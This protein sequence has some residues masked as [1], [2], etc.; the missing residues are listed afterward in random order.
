VNLLVKEL[1]SL[2]PL[3]ILVVLLQASD[4]IYDPFV[5]C[6]DM[7]AWTQET[8]YLPGEGTPTAIAFMI[9]ALLA[10][11][12]LFPR[13]HDDGT[14]HFLHSL[15]VSRTRIFLAKLAAAFLV[16]TLGV[17]WG[18]FTSFLVQLPNDETFT[19]HQFR[20][21]VA[22]GACAIHMAYCGFILAHAV[23]VSFFRRFGLV[24][25]GLAAWLVIALKAASPSLEF[26]DPTRLCDLE[27]EGT[28]LV[29][30]WSELAWQAGFALVALGLAWFLWTGPAERAGRAFLEFVKTLQGK[31]ALGCATA[32]IVGLGLALLVYLSLRAAKEAPEE[33]RYV[34]FHMVP[35]ETEHY[36]FSYPA[37][38]RERALILIRGA[39]ATYASVR[40]ALGGKDGA[41]IV[42]DLGD[43][44]ASHAGIAMWQKVRV[45]LAGDEDETRLRHVFH[46]ETAHAFQFQESGDK[47]Q[48]EFA[49]TQFFMEGGA[50]WAAFE[51]VSE[52]DARV[53]SR[54]LAIAAVRRRR[55]RFDDLCD[56]SGFASRHDKNLVYPVGETWVAALARA[57]GKEA[58]GNVLRSMGRKDAPRGLAPLPFWQ[59]TLQAAGYDLEKTNAAWNDLL[60]ELETKNRDFLERLP[61][62]GGG[63]ARLEEGAL[64]FVATLDREPLEGSRY[65]LKTRPNPTAGDDDTLWFRGTEK[66]GKIE[67]RVPSGSFH[68]REFEFQLGVVFD[69][70]VLPYFCEWQQ[71]SVPR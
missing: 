38:L 28:R 4:L 25:Y 70:R 48:R 37:N 21:Q 52:E 58:P 18:A 5:H 67:F 62:I 20:L 11:F 53:V 26:L 3:T 51:T 23:F 24:L 7:K 54:Q 44:S 60:D 19:G 47:A 12:S 43:T 57:H 39:D 8:G 66:D 34:S 69:A 71:G 22:L 10:G 9:L 45:C 56:A 63:V 16:L 17:V 6:L 27:Y 1:R 14:I 40:D 31:I 49:S 13:E 55:L 61:E 30:P 15:P 68:G 35:A 33:V 50:E 64:V 36:R 32:V 59:D 41:P 2:L 65:V 46:H 29:F 42:A